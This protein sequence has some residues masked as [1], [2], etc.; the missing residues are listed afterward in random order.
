MSQSLAGSGFVY[1]IFNK[2]TIATVA[3]SIIERLHYLAVVD[4]LLGMS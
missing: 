3:G 1:Y 4:K 2:G